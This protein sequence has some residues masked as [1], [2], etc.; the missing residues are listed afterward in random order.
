MLI[1]ANANAHTA[2]VAPVT[3]APPGFAARSLAIAS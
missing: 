1:G 3:K 2:S